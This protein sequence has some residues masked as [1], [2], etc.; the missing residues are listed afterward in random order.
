MGNCL[1]G[2]GP[3]RPSTPMNI[4]SKYNHIHTNAVLKGSISL[5]IHVHVHTHARVYPSYVL[6]TLLPVRTPRSICLAKACDSSDGWQA[7]VHACT[8]L[9]RCSQTLCP[10]PLLGPSAHACMPVRPSVHPPF[11]RLAISNI[12]LAAEDI[13]I[14]HCTRGALR[15]SVSLPAKKPWLLWSPYMLSIEDESRRGKK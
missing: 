2:R 8:A 4:I 13:S 1:P 3:P 15:G 10:P 5:N 6:D 14:I 12:G 7:C 11:C 9:P